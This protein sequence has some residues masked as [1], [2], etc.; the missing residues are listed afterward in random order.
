M[1]YTGNTQ[2]LS[3]AVL[4][5]AFGDIFPYGVAYAA[6]STGLFGDETRAEHLTGQ[7]LR[8]LSTVAAVSNLGLDESKVGNQTYVLTTCTPP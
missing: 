8:F 7:L 2:P 6:V 5:K 3:Y 4:V 1:T